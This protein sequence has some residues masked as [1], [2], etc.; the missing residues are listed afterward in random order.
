MVKANRAHLFPAPCAVIS[1]VGL[2]IGHVHGN[3]Q[4]GFVLFLRAP[5]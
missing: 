3:W 4:A 5:C 1:H 2:E